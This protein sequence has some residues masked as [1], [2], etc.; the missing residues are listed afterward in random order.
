MNIA[1]L[2]IIYFLFLFYVGIEKVDNY[3]LKNKNKKLDDEVM[4]LRLS[5]NENKKSN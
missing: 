5:K 1:L 3:K 4:K 2:I